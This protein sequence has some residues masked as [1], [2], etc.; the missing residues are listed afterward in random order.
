MSGPCIVQSDLTVL[1]EVDHPEFERAR[2]ILARFS[3]LI[4]SPE[5]MHTYRI[6]MLSLW[7]AA[8]SGCSA[9]WILT[10]LELVSRYP[11]PTTLRSEIENQVGRYGKLILRRDTE[12]GSLLLEAVDPLILTRIEKTDSLRSYLGER[13]SSSA[14]MVHDLQRGRLKHALIKM[15]WPVRDLAGY[16]SG[17]PF[18][19]QLRSQDQSGVSFS[20]RD[21]QHQAVDAFLGAGLEGGL[22]E[23]GNGV[24]ALPCGAGKT[25]VGM[26][27]MARFGFHTLILVANILAAR[28]WKRELLD[29]TDIP[30]ADIGEFS[31]ERKEIRP[32]TIATYQVVTYS[33]GASGPLAHFSLFDAQN[34][35]LI[36]YDEVHMLPAPVF[37]ITASLQARRRLG[38]TATLVREDG[39]EDEVFSLIGPK[40][41]D[42]PW[43]TLEEN[44]WIAQAECFE[45]RVPLSEERMIQYATEEDDK[46]RFRFSAENPAKENVV[47]MLLDRHRDDRVLVIGQYLDH[48]EKLATNLNLPLITGKS[49][50]KMRE[51]LFADFRDGRLMRLAV[52][53][54]ANIALDLP[55]A[56]CAIQISGRFGSRQEEA[57]RLGRILRPK[58]GVNKATFY[59]VVTQDTDEQQFARHRQLFLAEQG[60]RYSVVSASA[61]LTPASVL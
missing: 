47:E 13:V 36:I 58:K 49:P 45:V 2:D 23:G 3:E 24:V 56:N 33:A 29:K 20:L 26:A 35:G 34:W 32:V 8:A 40:R 59:T 21:Y 28:Q 12:S 44:G 25:L 5:R 41:F 43:K 52:S 61:L 17:S 38:L 11:L 1:L 15:G 53:S 10:N 30:S 50:T 31:G 27:V 14:L 42:I 9:E 39:K 57:Q 46:K 7:N 37:Q 19:L 4:K 55:D 48:L 51:K 22:A 16:T 54:I 18:R 6:S 60:Y